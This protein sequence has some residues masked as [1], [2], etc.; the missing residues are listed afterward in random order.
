MKKALKLGSYFFLTL[1]IFL[2]LP[3]FESLKL[4]D[5]SLKKQI[6]S[7]FQVGS[8]VLETQGEEKVP[9][10]LKD[11]ALED[12]Q[13]PELDTVIVKRV[14]DGD[15]IVLDDGT[16]V[17]YIGMNAPETYEPFGSQATLRNKELTE[18]KEVV[19]EFDKGLKDKYGR[20]LAYV[21]TEDY[22]I[23]EELL[24]EGM[25]KVMTIPPNEKYKDRFKKDEQGA[26]EQKLGIWK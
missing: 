6:L 19:L 20:T 3:S 9:E 7:K 5:V 21:Y 17:R 15:T 1:V 8:Q 16:K 25:A 23:N 18:G 11:Q 10:T 12:D 26:K 13:Y 14:I 4:N 22:F 24:K 2:F